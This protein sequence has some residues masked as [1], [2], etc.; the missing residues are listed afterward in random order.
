MGKLGGRGAVP[1]SPRD[2]SLRQPLIPAQLRPKTDRPGLL[3]AT[4]LGAPS[5]KDPVQVSVKL[6]VA[7]LTRS[8]P[9]RATISSSVKGG[10]IIP[11][12]GGGAGR[13]EEP[14]THSRTGQLNTHTTTVTVPSAPSDETT[15]SFRGSRRECHGQSVE[16]HSGVWKARG[17]VSHQQR[18]PSQHTFSEAQITPLG[19]QDFPACSDPPHLPTLGG[20]VSSARGRA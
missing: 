17:H 13:L 12:G 4:H 18:S 1:V 3:G 20:E 2:P 16:R 15:G 8:S 14:A 10:R 6:R 7:M 5:W 9:P 19:P 11:W